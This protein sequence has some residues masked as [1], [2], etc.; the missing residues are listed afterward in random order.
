MKNQS[1]L[2]IFFLSVFSQTLNAQ[3][4]PDTSYRP[5]LSL[6]SYPA[7]DGSVIHIDEAHKNFHTRGGRYTAFT[8][9]LE[10]DGYVLKSNSMKFDRNHLK[11]IQILVIANASANELS[12]PVVAPTPSAYSESEIKALVEWVNNGGSIF[13]IADHMPF[14]GASLHLAK[15][16]GFTCYDSFVMYSPRNGT[17]DFDRAEG[18]LSTN[19]LTEGRNQD[20]R[21]TR[22][23]SFTG[24]GF[25]IPDEATSILN[26]DDS[27][28]VYLTDTMWVFN[29]K[30]KSFPAQNLSQ[31]AIMTFGKGKV[32]MWGE[33][34]MFTAQISAK[35]G[36]KFGMS[37]DGAEQNYKLLLNIIHWLDG[38]LGE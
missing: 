6:K 17:I 37:S 15:A 24:Q 2:L 25:S 32:A 16:F 20:E 18:S 14:A 35:N 1:L 23:R 8:R 12:R 33:A 22:V 13:L 10:S 34:A 38:L 4:R 3:Q 21:V 36:Q 9:L 28:N 30:V 7:N 11:D 26:L 27:Q 5:L 31:G 19:F 29:E